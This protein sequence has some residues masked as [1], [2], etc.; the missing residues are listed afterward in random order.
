MS[1]T[2]DPRPQVYV[3]Y[4][5]TPRLGYRPVPD[6]AA[7]TFLHATT[8]IERNSRLRGPWIEGDSMH[9]WAARRTLVVE[10]I[11]AMPLWEVTIGQLL[12]EG[13]SGDRETRRTLWNERWGQITRPP[14]ATA[15]IDGP[16][17][18]SRNPMVWVIAHAVAETRTR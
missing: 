7:I 9:A 15:P 14:W 4:R 12:A 17:A 11:R 5:A 2:R 16:C 3:A 1:S 13:L 18:W 10:T 6:R 8:P